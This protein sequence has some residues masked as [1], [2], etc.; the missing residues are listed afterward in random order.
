[1]AYHAHFVPPFQRRERCARA[2]VY[3]HGRFTADV[4]HKNV[5]APALLPLGAGPAADRQVQPPQQFI[6]EG[7]WD[8]TALGEVDG[9]LLSRTW[10][11]RNDSCLL[12]GR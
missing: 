9:V 11:S 1:M 12:L 7:G 3:L 2:A 10:W 4:P 6:G 8:G 5:E